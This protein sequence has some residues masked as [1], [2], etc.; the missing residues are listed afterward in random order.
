MRRRW[1]ELLEDPRPHGVYA[2]LRSDREEIGVEWKVNNP[3]ATK[4]RRTKRGAVRNGLVKKRA[5]ICRVTVLTVSECVPRR[6]RYPRMALTGVVVTV[7]RAS[8]RR[9]VL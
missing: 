1:L 2:A 4:C 7:Y 3:S 6:S 5:V 8:S 9:F